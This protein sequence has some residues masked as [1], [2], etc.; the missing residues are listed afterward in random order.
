MITIESEHMPVQYRIE[1]AD[2][3]GCGVHIAKG[4]AG[5][6]VTCIE[7]QEVVGV[8]QSAELAIVMAGHY[9]TTYATDAISEYDDPDTGDP[10][11]VG[12]TATVRQGRDMMADP[13]RHVVFLDE[14]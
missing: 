12:W 3:R 2:D 5:Y 1:T 4:D 9:L 6:A 8:A 10:V 7:T 13:A 14:S 11:A